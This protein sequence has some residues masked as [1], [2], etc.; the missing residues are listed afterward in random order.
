MNGLQGSDQNGGNGAV[1][2]EIALGGGSLSLVVWLWLLCFRGQF[3]RSDLVLEQQQQGETSSFPAVCA[4]I[5]ARNEANLLPQTLSSLL[6]QDYPGQFWVMLV[7]DHSTDGTAEIA[8]T[9]AED[10]GKSAQ[11]QVMQAQPLPAGWSGKLWAM[12]QGVEAA[13]RLASEHLPDYLL[14]TDA[15]IQHDLTNLQRLVELAVRQ[16]L[17]LASVMVRLRCESYWEQ[18]LIPAFVF[19]FEKLYPFRWV[20]DPRNSTAAA[21]GGCILI[22]RTALAR[23]GGLQRIRQALI[24]DCALAAAVKR[25]A[26][27]TASLHPIWLG[28]SDQTISL[29]PYPSLQSIWDMVARTAF[30]QL[31]YSPILL[32]GTLFGMTVVYILPVLGVLV[33]GITAD[34][35]VAMIGLITW[36]LMTLAYLPTVRFYRC[37][38]IFAAALPL[39]A[40]LY[41]GMTLDSALRYWQGRGGAWKGRVYPSR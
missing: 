37:P 38:L 31:D 7:D 16:N 40:S 12:Q 2:E 36:G 14:L 9:T 35:L 41:T 19:F 32:A 5:P 4:V 28:L 25:E 30:T 29:R 27:P 21:A 11:L 8:R 34:W 13:E 15:D 6:Q 23:I 39:I 18:L 20:N 3:W 24:D 22:R 26:D 17:D 33:G 1:I 10:L